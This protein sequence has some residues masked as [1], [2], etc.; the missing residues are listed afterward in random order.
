VATC[1]LA[2]SA[3][4]IEKLE[5]THET[6]RGIQSVEIRRNYK[7]AYFYTFQPLAPAR[8]NESSWVIDLVNGRLARIRASM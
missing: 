2:F 4:E 3:E 1:R 7:G 6:A 5:Q 8:E